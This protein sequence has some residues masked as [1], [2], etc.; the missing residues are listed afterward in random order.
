MSG[1]ENIAEIGGVSIAITG[2]TV[3][4]VVL[5]TIS[6]FITLLPKALDLLHQYHPEAEH[7]REPVVESSRSTSP[8]EAIAVAIGY[9]MHMNS[10]D[11]GAE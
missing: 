5:T 6:G 8:D 1:W 10:R 9:A 2:M 4:F 7:H 3:V 11:S